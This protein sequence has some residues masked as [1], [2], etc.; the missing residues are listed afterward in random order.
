MIDSNLSPITD[1][2]ILHCYP[3][4]MIP[5]EFKDDTAAESVLVRDYQSSLETGKKWRGG[6]RVVLEYKNN[7]REIAMRPEK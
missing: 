1:Y 7:T 3:N 6:R 2:A 4:G 5:M